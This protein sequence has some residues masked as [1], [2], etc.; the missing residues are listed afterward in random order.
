MNQAHCC[1]PTPKKKIDKLLW[2]SLAV[3][4][5][6]YVCHFF[7]IYQDI[8]WF[9]H[10]SMSFYELMNK[11]WL[12]L[13]LGIFFVGLL[14]KVPRTFV[15][16]IIGRPGSLSGLFRATLAGLLLDLCSHGVLLVGMKLYERGASLGQTFAFLI[17]SPWNSLSLTII[18]AALIGWKATIMFIL[19]SAVIAMVS[20]IIFD[21][22]E[23]TAPFLATR[24]ACNTILIFY[25]GLM[26]NRVLQRPHSI[27]LSYLL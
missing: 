7:G 10:L 19:I 27:G 6:G 17:A 25:F 13:G 14:D 9:H 11:M 24:T 12:G 8:E 2:G 5:F 3:V 15:L 22:L 23:K 20:G 4:A 26:R 1:T 21:R 18:L 16:S